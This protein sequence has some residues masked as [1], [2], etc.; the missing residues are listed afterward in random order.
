MK[1][2]KKKAGCFTTLTY[3]FVF[4]IV[5]AFCSG[6]NSDS[7]EKKSTEGLDPET[8]TEAIVTPAT[9]PEPTAEPTVAPTAEPSTLQEWAEY[10]AE[11]VYGSFDPK[12]SNLISVSC[13]QV[14]GETAPMITINAKY[15]D[16]FARDN[17]ERMGGFLF[18]AM[19]VTWELADLEKSGKI[20]YGSVF[21]HG[22][23]TFVDKYGNETEGDAANIRIKASEA[24][25]V[26]WG[27]STFTAEMLPG[28]A[29]AFGIN[30]IIRD[31]LSLQY[32]NEI[33]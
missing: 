11:K 9:T 13:E 2:R 30:P 4:I 10:V 6:L 3:G 20:E 19:K 14:D 29:V 26:N 17:D 22:R 8:T 16:T 21:I 7:S 5:L 33:R 24:A 32:L 28:V 27:Y 25:K 31:G 23:T 18:N 15:P 12:Y 1:K